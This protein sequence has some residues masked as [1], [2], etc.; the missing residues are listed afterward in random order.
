[1]RRRCAWCGLDMG[2]KEPLG[3]DH[4][5][6][7]MCLPCCEEII[8]ASDRE[9]GASACLLRQRRPEGDAPTLVEVFHS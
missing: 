1:M 8:R 5:T 9:V 2:S 3:D 7:G 6:H 4:L